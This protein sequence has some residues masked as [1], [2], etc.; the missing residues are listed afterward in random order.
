MA[1]YG[2][3]WET[4][5]VKTCDGWHLTM[6]RILGAKEAKKSDKLPVLVQHGYGM[7]ATSWLIG[8]MLDTPWPLKLVD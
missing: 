8:A 6:F 5:E 4:H 2:Y 3:D 1:P 7:Y